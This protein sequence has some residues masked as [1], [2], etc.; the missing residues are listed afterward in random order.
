MAKRFVITLATCA[1]LA[2][3]AA[4]SLGATGCGAEDTGAGSGIPT[5]GGSGGG[6]ANAGSAGG[7]AGAAGT[8]PP[9][10]CG[11]NTCTSSFF[12]TACCRK[13]NTCGLG[14]A[15]ECLELN[16]EGTLDT[17]CADQAFIAFGMVAKGCCKSTGKCGLMLT[18]IGL[19]CVERTAIPA[20]ASSGG[21]WNA[22]LCTDADSGM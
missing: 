17:R 11:A 5:G 13:D 10:T 20:W 1:S 6:T 2:L 4:L 22:A 21:E 3:C 19:G 15:D 16:Q 8:T 7:I 9:L 14:T 18:R 12:T